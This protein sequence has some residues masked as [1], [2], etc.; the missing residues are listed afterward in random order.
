MPLLFWYPMIVWSGMIGLALEHAQP[1][2]G[3]FRIELIRN[4]NAALDEREHDRTENR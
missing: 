4:E 3:S 1:R 2:A